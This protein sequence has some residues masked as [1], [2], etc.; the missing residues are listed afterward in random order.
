MLLFKSTRFKVKNY[1]SDFSLEIKDP[2]LQ[3][4]NK[5]LVTKNEGNKGN[6]ED[7]EKSIHYSNYI[8]NWR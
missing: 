5:H 7:N 4:A 8:M 3:E 6:T 1:Q 2:F